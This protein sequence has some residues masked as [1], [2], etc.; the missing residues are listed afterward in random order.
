MR[1]VYHSRKPAANA[2]EWAEYFADFTEFLKATDVLSIH[3]PLKDET[4]GLVGEKEIRT[5]RKGS[6][7]VNTAR[8]KVLDEEALIRALKDGHVRPR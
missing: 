7:L 2:P 4:V 5:L 3:V 1:V 6:I 8:G